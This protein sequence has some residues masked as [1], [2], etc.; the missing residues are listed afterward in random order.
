MSRL[1]FAAALVAVGLFSL[2]TT[3]RAANDAAASPTAQPATH[4]VANPSSTAAEHTAVAMRPWRASE[5]IGLKVEDPQGRSLGKIE[6][7][8]FNPTNG[9]I[10]YAVLSFGG[11][12]GMGDKYFAIP[13]THLR[14]EEMATKG[15][16]QKF[17]LVL[18]VSETKLKNAPGFDS[19]NWPDF[20]NSA[21]GTSVR[22]FYG[23]N[24]NTSSAHRTSPTTNTK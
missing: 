13:W 19:K 23:E 6:D 4:A 2:A 11:V 14:S 24:T 8:V 17:A 20:G 21:Y 10:R 12:A 3:A 18:D 22:Q 5:T 9:H 1:L 16:N 7:I 15:G